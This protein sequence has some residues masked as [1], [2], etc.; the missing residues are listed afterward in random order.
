MSQK[1]LKIYKTTTN[2]IFILPITLSIIF[3][4]HV[5]RRITPWHH[6]ACHQQSTKCSLI[7]E[8]HSMQLITY[9]KLSG[10]HFFVL[11]SFTQH[12]LISIMGGLPFES[13]GAYKVRY[14]DSKSQ[15][16]YFPCKFW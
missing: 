1:D 16:I 2:T 8:S 14:V 5:A 9:K 13:V 7:R 11:E 12:S 15:N 4:G 3:A 6:V 10:L